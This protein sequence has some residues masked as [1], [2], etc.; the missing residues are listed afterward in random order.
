[1]LRANDLSSLDE[2]GHLVPFSPFGALPA[3]SHNPASTGIASPH[4][5]MSAFKL[6]GFGIF[7]SPL[8]AL[9]DSELI[10]RGHRIL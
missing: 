8:S 1:M 3:Y 2:P 5:T 9:L 7:S 6:T 4:L 10:T